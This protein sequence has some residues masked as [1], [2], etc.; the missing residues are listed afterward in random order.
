MGRSP[1]GA[2][3]LGEKG[4]KRVGG[5]WISL[6]CCTHAARWQ[7]ISCYRP[8]GTVE[9]CVR[10]RTA[11]PG[12]EPWRF[13]DAFGATWGAPIRVPGGGRKHSE[14]QQ[15][16]RTVSA[17]HSRGGTYIASRSMVEVR[18]SDN[19]SLS[20]AALGGPR[21]CAVEFLEQRLLVFV[22]VPA[23]ADWGQALVKPDE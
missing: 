13:R 22:L 3:V 10:D 23:L 15:V 7:S 2:P 4:F 6:E 21:Q 14:E 17:Y 5:G 20:A 19:E 11:T 9:S 18:S 12:L 8:E 16:G 1:S